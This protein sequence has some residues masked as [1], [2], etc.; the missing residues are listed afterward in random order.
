MAY[1]QRLSQRLKRHK[2][3]ETHLLCWLGK[4]VNITAGVLNELELERESLPLLLARVQNEAKLKDITAAKKYVE[5]LKVQIA[6]LEKN[7]KK[8]EYEV[9]NKRNKNAVDTFSNQGT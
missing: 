7:L 4:I 9:K 8:I 1:N 3:A 6:G 5:E 2:F